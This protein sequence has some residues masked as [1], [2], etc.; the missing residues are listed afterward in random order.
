MLYVKP[1]STDAAVHFSVEAYFMEQFPLTRPLFMIWQADR[2]AMIGS[3]QVARA[4]VN[5][6]YAGEQNIQIVRRQSGGGTI[7][8][9]MGTLLYTLILPGSG[10]MSPADVVKE[11]FAAPMIRALRKLG[12][13][14]ELKGRNDILVAGK[15]VCGIAQHARR[16]R[17]CTHGSLLYDTD[18]DMLASVLQVDPAKIQSKAIPSIRSR[19]TNLKPY[20]EHPVSTPEFRALLEEK[21]AEEWDMCPYTLTEADMTRVDT[22]Y[23]ERFGNPNWS[24]DRTPRF[25]F[26]NSKRFPGG[27]VTVFLDIR[28]ETVAEAAICGD[29][30]GTVPIRGLE[31]ALE[32]QAFQYRSIAQILADVDLRPFLGEISRDEF[33][34]CLFD[35]AMT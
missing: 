15:K 29:F 24:R 27:R 23:R 34:S 20:M 12:I 17:I 18:L 2:T 9:D 31:A 19:V 7:F 26:R 25:S 10:D 16:G 5:A 33:L 13:P 22:I 28:R 32:G 1:P 35:E 30:L 4:E 21:L 3:Y 14:A 6:R 8:T 11:A